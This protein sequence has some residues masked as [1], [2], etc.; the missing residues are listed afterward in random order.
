MNTV[1]LVTISVIVGACFASAVFLVLPKPSGKGNLADTSTNLKP[2]EPTR[3]VQ[4]GTTEDGRERDALLTR[5]MVTT[6]N[7]HSLDEL[8]EYKSPFDRS[9]ALR[10]MLSHANEQQTLDLL[11]ESKNIKLSS[12]AQVQS[13]IF[14]RMAQLSP[15][16]ALSRLDGLNAQYTEEFIVSIFGEWSRSN[17]EEAVSHASSMDENRKFSAMS[18]ILAER[19]D[20]SVAKRR[21]IARRLGN[22]Q[23]AINLIVLEKVSD[24]TLDPRDAWY[25]LVDE[26][27]NDFQQLWTLV[28]IANAWVNKSGLDVLNQVSESITSTQARTTVLNSVLTNVAQADPE[29]AFEYSLKFDTAGSNTFVSSVVAIWAGTDPTAAL[30]AVAQIDKSGLRRQLEQSVTNAWARQSP[31]DVLAN[32]DQLS[33]HLQRSAVTSAT[34]A[35]AHRDPTKAAELVASLEDGIP[36][37]SAANLLASIWSTRDPKSALAWILGEPSIEHLRPQLLSNTLFRVADEDPLF[38]FETALEQPIDEGSQGL[39]VTVISALA[40]F[41][42]DKAVQ[43]LPRV[44]KG[45]TQAASYAIVGA[46]YIR[47]GE[48]QKA[49][50]LAQT[51]PES[52]RTYYLKELL[53]Q[54]AGSDPQGLLSA[55]D[56]LPTDEIKSRAALALW[57]YDS[58]HNHLSDEELELAKRFLSDEDAENAKK[59]I[60]SY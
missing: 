15:R 17:L 54:W 23:Y 24:S 56:K 42:F 13:V 36:K 18:S 1:L 35:I 34:S 19:S 43:F 53:P 28:D 31:F 60:I 52:N 44:R 2:P 26:L 29:G 9:I 51:L 10:G 16:S 39:E 49:L 21:E 20:L 37:T 7:I 45:R 22:E 6:A 47:E 27:Q 25:E 40:R 48:T 58:L 55:I 14:Q 5:S 4:N 57:V 11:E 41:D 8:S 38:A 12:R 46:G 32:L 33:D 50:E 3:S 59:G 30:A